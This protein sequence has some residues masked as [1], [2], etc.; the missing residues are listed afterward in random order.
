[1]SPLLLLGAI[2]CSKKQMRLEEVLKRLDIITV[3]LKNK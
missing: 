3:V 1:M 2:L